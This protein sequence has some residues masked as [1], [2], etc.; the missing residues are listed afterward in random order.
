MFAVCLA[1]H[2]CTYQHTTTA[3]R[4]RQAAVYT[5]V[6]CLKVSLLYNTNPNW[7][8][9]GTMPATPTPSGP[10]WNHTHPI[11]SSLEPHPPQK[12]AATPTH[13]SSLGTTPTQSIV[14]TPT[15]PGP[16]WGP[17]PHHKLQSHPPSL[18]RGHAHP[19]IVGFKL[20]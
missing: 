6:A 19:I 20:L 17:R 18:V 16:H 5:T 1:K 3:L 14:T 8:S 7:S 2:K 9:W 15:P 4:R 12:F 13:R 10:H 11:R